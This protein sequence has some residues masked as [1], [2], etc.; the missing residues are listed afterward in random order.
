MPNSSRPK[1]QKNE[2]NAGSMADIAF[3]LL[4]FFL[5]STKII[6]DQGI[7]VKLPPH[8]DDIIETQFN[9]NNVFTVK[10]NAQNQILA[11]GTIINLDELKNATKE[12]ITNPMHRL[13]RPAKPSKAIVSLQNDRGTNYNTYLTVY[14]EL[15]AAYSELRTDLAQSR[16]GK[17]F[18]ALSKAQK[19]EIRTEIPLVISEAEPTEF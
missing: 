3:L 18:K 9:E 19:I 8:N 1:R 11:E 4:I 6:E 10:V 14:N 12:F 16:Y 13:D 2:V 15:Q 7:L 5:V 17:D